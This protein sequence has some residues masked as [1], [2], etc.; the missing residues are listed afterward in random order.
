MTTAPSSSTGPGR[1][2]AA[3]L[4]STAVLCSACLIKS[5][6]GR[7]GRLMSEA[8]EIAWGRVADQDV[9]DAMRLYEEAP[10]L[11]ALVEAI[12]RELAGRTA[13]PGLPWTF[14]V[15]DDPAVNAFA[16]PGG[17]VY[18]TRGL[19]A[20]LGSR[21]ELAAV[22]GHEA[23][24]V[25]ARHAAI[26]MRNAQAA[27]RRIQFLAS[28]VDPNR[29]HVAAVAATSARLTMLDYGRE[30]EL[31]ADELGLGYVQEAGY[32]PTAFL[33]V[34]E[35]L[36]AVSV[37]SPRVPSWLSSHPEPAERSRSLAMRLGA[38]EPREDGSP[39]AVDAEYVALLAGM[40][41]GTDPRE[42][43][44]DATTYRH[45]RVGFRVELPAGWALEQD[46]SGATALAPDNLSQLG[47]A[48]RFYDYPTAE[49]ATMAFFISGMFRRHGTETVDVAGSRMML[50]EYSLPTTLGDWMGLVGFVDF[51]GHVVALMASAPATI[52]PQHVEAVT[53]TFGSL[54]PLS[55]PERAAL[56]PW[57]VE[58]VPVKEETTLRELHAA[59]RLAV[60][61]EVLAV[62]NRVGTDQA[63]EVTRPM[64]LVLRPT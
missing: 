14:R 63:L 9:Q 26:E 45:G 6:G 41:Y 61:L 60:P 35:L 46:A 37:D 20:H 42:G 51:Q 48:P 18:V 16:L 17:H 30:G 21:D 58:V 8:D 62:L 36:G 40:V 19:L 12:G 10:E 23:G 11:T 43:R 25:E 56:E 54:R 28:V 22:L 7:S 55:E 49:K 52:W 13:R 64:K 44:L 38:K 27:Q 29:Q 50:T 53:A 57:R 47:V 32:E 33:T 15:L 1:L 4:L 34:F 5:T 31:Q 2:C 39:P 59:R 24:H 3:A